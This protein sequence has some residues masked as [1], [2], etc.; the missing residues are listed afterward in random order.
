MT[1]HMV[2]DYI[3]IQIYSELPPVM[4]SVHHPPSKCFVSF[5][6][7]GVVAFLLVES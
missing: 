4:G 5:Y 6:D 2:C 1:A 3:T 7:V